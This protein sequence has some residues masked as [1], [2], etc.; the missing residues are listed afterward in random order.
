MA[1]IIRAKIK[2]RRD[3]GNTQAL[4]NSAISLAYAG[5]YPEST[6]FSSI[7]PHPLKIHTY[8]LTHTCN[9]TYTCSI[10]SNV[11]L[12]CDQKTKSTAANQ[13]VQTILQW[14]VIWDCCSG[15]VNWKIPAGKHAELILQS[16]AETSSNCPQKQNNS[17]ATETAAW[18]GGEELY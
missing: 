3:I 16:W 17:V 8:T 13:T 9:S 5:H 12:T 15:H 6:A 14:L 11:M 4:V 10:Q 7:N 18:E 1:L 2:F